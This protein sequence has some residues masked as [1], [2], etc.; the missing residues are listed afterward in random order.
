[1]TIEDALASLDV[2]PGC[3]R[4]DETESLDGSGYAV[5][6]GLASD[7]ELADLRAR[8]EAG[9]TDDWPYPRGADIRHAK[10]AGDA[11][12]LA[13]CLHARV[14]QAVYH[15]FRRRFYLASFEGRE[16][17]PGGGYQ[18]LHRDCP[19]GPMAVATLLLFL[20]PFDASNGATR[21]VPA[22]HCN[23]D[24]VPGSD[25]QETVIS[26]AGGD[27]ILFDARLIHGGSRNQTGAPRR[28]LIAAYHGY[29]NFDGRYFNLPP[30]PESS[31][32]IRY[33][34][35]EISGGL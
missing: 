26:G 3:L 6:R 18:S 5:L 22:S 28:T 9:V 4:K 33:M 13:L 15:L 8:F 10:L 21:L 30:P 12:F 17:R 24:A 32:A 25:P 35:G 1:M 27:A 34:L 31:A 7:D 29:E 23:S 14:L 19:F 16:P 2:T 20:D 11:H